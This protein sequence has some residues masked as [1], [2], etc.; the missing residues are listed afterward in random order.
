MAMNGVSFSFI[1]YNE[2]AMFGW[3]SEK[4]SKKLT[5][6]EDQLTI[7]VKDGSGF[8]TSFGD[9]VSAFCSDTSNSYS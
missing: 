3:D 4:T 2:L 1:L 5:I 8:K 9:V 7:K 6:D